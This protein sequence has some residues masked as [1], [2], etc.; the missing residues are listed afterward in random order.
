MW[1]M[2]ILCISILTNPA[3]NSGLEEMYAD[4]LKQLEELHYKS[5]K[6]YSGAAF[7]LSKLKKKSSVKPWNEKEIF[8]SFD[9]DSNGIVSPTEL[10]LGLKTKFGLQLKQGELDALCEDPITIHS[11]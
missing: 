6:R 5:V 1:R 9:E 10:R 3:P 7:R 4:S 11:K 8:H 2:F